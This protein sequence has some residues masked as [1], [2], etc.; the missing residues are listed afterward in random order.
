MWQVLLPFM[1]TSKTPCLRS[2]WTNYGIKVMGCFI[3]A[4]KLY[5]FTKLLVKYPLMGWITKYLNCCL[6]QT[7]H[8]NCALHG[9][10]ESTTPKLEDISN[11]DQILQRS[12]QPSTVVHRG[13]NLS[14]FNWILL[15]WKTS[16]IKIKSSNDLY[17]LQWL[18]TEASTWSFSI[19]FPLRNWA[20][21]MRS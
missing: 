18:F 3:L 15:S 2:L 4:E 7:Q 6:T 8:K 16:I 20:P 1:M 9:H 14:L 12:L 11:Q 17:N 21:F 19:E 10:L 13:F 5:S